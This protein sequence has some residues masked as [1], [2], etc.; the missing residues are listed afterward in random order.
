MAN[1]LLEAISLPDS[2]EKLKVFIASWNMGNA[3]QEGI[4]FIFS[5]K[6]ALEKYDVFAI[7]LQESTYI[8]ESNKT[9]DPIAHLKAQLEKI[10]ENKFYVIEHCYRAQLQLFV[11]GR[12]TLKKRITNIEKCVENTGFL[13]VFPN[14]G[15]LLITF[16]V[17]GTKL[18][19]VSCHL[20]AH[21]GIK[22]CEDRNASI[23]EIL[24]GVRAG[25]KTYDIT[26]QFHHVWWMGK[27]IY[28]DFCFIQFTL[29]LSFPLR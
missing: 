14:K 6:E 19:F 11:F 10:F 26:E 3:E 8:L 1:K 9:A 23:I 22:H 2:N 5:E 17:D 20:A 15:G 4:N 24:G 12:K 29:L 28:S 25:D 21:E 27:F 7:G 16:H 13:H 18:A